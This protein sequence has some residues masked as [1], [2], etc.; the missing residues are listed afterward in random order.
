MTGFLTP[1]LVDMLQYGVIELGVLATGV[2]ILAVTLFGTLALAT[3]VDV[4]GGSGSGPDL[5]EPGGPDLSDKE[6]VP[7]S[8][9]AV[10]DDTETDPAIE[11][12]PTW[13]DGHRTAFGELWAA[14][15]RRKKRRKL[16]K[17]G[18]I[19]WHL[20]DGTYP[21]PNFI[22]PKRTGAGVPE[23]KHNG[24]TYIFPDKAALPSEHSGM[25]VF[26]HRAGEMDPIN[27]RDPVD[28][29]IAP[30]QFQ[31]YADMSLQTSSPGI[32][33]D[34]DPWD[35]MMYLGGASVVVLVANEALGLGLL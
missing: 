14:R 16:S 2:T 33:S 1:A 30:D 12:D 27:L 13:I 26:V 10:E 22:K 28:H 19:Q 29:A 20:V 3:D 4:P 15:R 25:R 17:K 34:I 18:Y 8:E 21:N 6:R 7:L 32:L 31:E 35:A 11:A 24:E 23:Y 9:V 5:D